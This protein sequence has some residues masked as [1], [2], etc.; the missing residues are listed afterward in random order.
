MVVGGST[1]LILGVVIELHG[2]ISLKYR[3]ESWV[4]QSY[5]F[6]VEFR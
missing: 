2:R 3:L 5:R 1:S 4:L 6:Y